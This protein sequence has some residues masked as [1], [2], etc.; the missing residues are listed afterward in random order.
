MSVEQAKARHAGSV[1][2]NSPIVGRIF[3]GTLGPVLII[4]LAII[5]L[6]YV[7]VIRLNAPWAYDQ[8]QRANTELSFS[9]LVANTMAQE[10]PVLPAPHQVI[11][12]LWDT[13]IAKPITSKRS[14]IY[15]AWITLSA[16]L[17]GFT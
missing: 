9:Q 3:A 1:P 2:Q 16:T 10:R 4:C 17:L 15:H 12:E 14:L 5:A 11:A 7:A 8:A 6:W 13:T